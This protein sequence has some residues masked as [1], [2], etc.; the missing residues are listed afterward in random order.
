MTRKRLV[1]LTGGATTLAIAVGLVAMWSAREAT[2]AT[3]E[4]A[5]VVETYPHDA[6]AYCQ[7]LVFHDGVLYEGTGKY[8][9]SSLRKVVLETGQVLERRNLSNRYFGEGI[10]ILG[11]KIYQLTWRERVALVYDLATLRPTGETFRYTGEGW[12]LT[13]DGT[14]LIMS[15]GTSVLRVID[16]RTFEVVRRI[17][18]QDGRRRILNLN[19][20]EYVDGEIYANV[21]QEDYIARISPRNG[22]V[23]GW[24]DLRGLLPANLR[25]ANDHVLNGIAY[26][27]ATGRLFVTGKNWPRL[28]QIRL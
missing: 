22:Q 24:I 12:G 16:P 20:L 15:D 25:R 17:A 27:P 13:T 5:T 26:D 11:G 2:P 28:Y 10:A 14:H 18:V 6:G 9:Q 3:V 4:R 8:G 23:V 21:W 19:E 1:G 7:G